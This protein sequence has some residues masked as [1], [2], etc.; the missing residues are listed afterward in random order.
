MSHFPYGILSSLF[1]DTVVLPW[2]STLPLRN[3]MLLNALLGRVRGPCSGWKLKR[4][5]DKSKGLNVW[6]QWSVRTATVFK[7]D[8]QVQDAEGQTAGLWLWPMAFPG[9]LTPNKPLRRADVKLIDW[10]KLFFFF[11]SQGKFSTDK[12]GARFPTCFLTRHSIKLS[13]QNSWHL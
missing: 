5:R 7:G 10:S 13:W 9:M 4:G 3:K 12:N 6:Q 1:Y 11:P 2:H 8:G